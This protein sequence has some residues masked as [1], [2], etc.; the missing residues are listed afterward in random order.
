MDRYLTTDQVREIDRRAV[1]ECGMSSLVLMENAAR[2]VLDVMLRLGVNGPVAICCGWGNNGGDGL[3]LARLLDGLG[4]DVRV[5]L[6]AL[7]SQLTPDASANLA[8][9]RHCDVR[10]ELC[11]PVDLLTRH[12]QLLAGADWVVDALFGSGFR[13]EF[14]PPYGAVTRQLNQAQARRLAID[15]PSGLD[16]NSGHAAE[17]TVHAD[18]TVTLVAPKIGFREPAAAAY[19]GQVHIANIGL[20]RR[21]VEQVLRG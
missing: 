11:E 13:G 19:L 9:L 16:A 21:L 7:N 14:R 1:S 6:W 17:H 2:G 5:A 18:H 3:A 15:V 8:V 12:P 10:L 4:Y 20:P